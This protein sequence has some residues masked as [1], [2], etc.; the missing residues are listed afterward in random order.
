M[1]RPDKPSCEHTGEEYHSAT[2]QPAHPAATRTKR[3]E[4]LAEPQ[5]QTLA[6]P[7]K[8]DPRTLRRSDRALRTTSNNH[9]TG[10]PDTDDGIAARI[11]KKLQRGMEK[12]AEDRSPAL[13]HPLGANL[14][15]DASGS[16][17]EVGNKLWYHAIKTKDIAHRNHLLSSFCRIHESM[18]A[19]NG[20]SEERVRKSQR[21]ANPDSELQRLHDNGATVL[22]WIVDGLYIHHG[23]KALLFYWASCSK[24][25]NS[26]MLLLAH[27]ILEVGYMLASAAKLH[28]ERRR[29]IAEKVVES[30]SQM[31]I[32]VTGHAKALHPGIF[33]KCYNSNLK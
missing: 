6:A 2:P 32:N 15:T 29:S 4:A 5:G 23:M 3:S 28:I 18:L 20:D 27:S 7:P 30:L 19:A 31:H 12:L 21:K 14:K 33:L 17:E 22:S 24:Y 8:D 16:I 9:P 10:K 11:T 25:L 1:I 26:F 13:W